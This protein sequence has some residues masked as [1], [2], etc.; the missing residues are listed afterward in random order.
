MKIGVNVEVMLVQVARRPRLKCSDWDGNPV[1]YLRG[2]VG[3]SS[4]R[5]LGQDVSH[6]LAGGKRVQRSKSVG[7]GRKLLHRGGRQSNVRELIS[8]V[9]EQ[10]VLDDRDADVSAGAFAINSPRLRKP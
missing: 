7:C 9:D 1:D 4:S 5:E 3:N 2:R 10:L 6:L 8:A